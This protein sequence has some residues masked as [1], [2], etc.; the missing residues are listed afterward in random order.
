VSGLHRL[1]IFLRTAHP[2][3]VQPWVA[4]IG[5]E[6]HSVTRPSGSGRG[7]PLFDRPQKGRGSS[8]RVGSGF[9][10]FWL[11]G[12][13][14]G[15][16]QGL[17]GANGRS[18]MLCCKPRIGQPMGESR[19]RKT[20]S[21]SLQRMSYGPSKTLS[22]SP[23]GG[24][25]LVPEVGRTTGPCVSPLHRGEQEGSSPSQE[26]TCS[27]RSGEPPAPCVSPP[28]AFGGDQERSSDAK[29]ASVKGARPVIDPP[30]K[31][32]AA[33]L[34]SLSWCL[35]SARHHRDASPHPHERSP[36]YSAGEI[37]QPLFPPAADPS[38]ALRRRPTPLLWNPDERSDFGG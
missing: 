3:T 16:D 35:P 12:R 6:A 17:W 22:V 27:R 21:V 38:A 1:E 36:R 7:R 14:E 30:R 23:S 25:D 4:P 34:R 20:L 2:R 9:S 24:E 37:L 33:L 32:K 13:I 8:A 31:V 11:S 15:G 29:R 5:L 10:V 19:R 28:K 18:T 26:R